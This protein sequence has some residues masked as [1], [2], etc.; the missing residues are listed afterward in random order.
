MVKPKS[1]LLSNADILHPKYIGVTGG[2]CKCNFKKVKQGGIQQLRKQLGVP[3]S[4]PLKGV[5]Q[6]NQPAVKKL[7]HN[8]VE[9]PKYLS[10]LEKLQ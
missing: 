8:W 3:V 6:T 9:F 7:L 4:F 2:T 10:K 1:L 5:H